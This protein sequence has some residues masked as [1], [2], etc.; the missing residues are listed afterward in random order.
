MKK[1]V[2]MLVIA[3]T[4]SACEKEVVEPVNEAKPADKEVHI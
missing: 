2:L 4:L 1:Y 3:T